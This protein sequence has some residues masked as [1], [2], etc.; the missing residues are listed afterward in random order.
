LEEVL[1]KIDMVN[2]QDLVL[3]DVYVYTVADDSPTPL[4]QGIHMRIARGEWVNIV[5]RNGSGKSTLGRLLTGILPVS[6]GSLK[7]G[8]AGS[9]PV[10]Y[11]M[12]Q[13]GQLFGDTPWED[14]VFLLEVRGTSPSMI[15]SAAAS[16]LSRVGLAAEMHRPIAELSG[17]QKQ[18]TATAGC[19]AADAPLLLF[20]EA[21]SMLDSTS[22]RQVLEAAKNL[23]NKGATVIWLTH[24]MEEL[25]AGERVIAL[26]QGQ[27]VFDGTVSS[28]FYGTQCESLGFEPPFPVQVAK[29]LQSM[30][31][32]LTGM[33]IT[34]E[35][36]AEAVRGH[37][38]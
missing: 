13:D 17:G 10:P 4:L 6:E 9:E 5:G 28:F 8:F 3:N 36:L 38:G 21:T 27:I 29:E 30:G 12:Q 20:D 37:A 22:R 19:L 31:V 35:Q 1:E 11:V 24:H 2:Q 14:V 25:F 16:A 26:D 32:P 18:L 34:T 7:R 15:R 23:H 33:P